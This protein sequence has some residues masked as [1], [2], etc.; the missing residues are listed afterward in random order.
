MLASP[1]ST[2]ACSVEQLVSLALDDAGLPQLQEVRALAGGANHRALA[3][4]LVDGQRLFAK[5]CLPSDVDQRQRL[6]V[7]HLALRLMWQ[8][9]ERAIPEPLGYLDE[10]CLLCRFVEGRP[11]L[12]RRATAD[13]VAQLVAFIDRLHRLGLETARAAAPLASDA[14]LSLRQART[15][16]ERRLARLAAVESTALG[17]FLEQRFRPAL[18][19]FAEALSADVLD[20]AGLVVLSPSDFGFHNALVGADG[21]R[22]IF[23]DFEY[24]GWDDAGKLI[25]DTLLHPQHRELSLPL[26][27]QL[28]DGMLAVYRERD[29]AL[30]QRVR[31]GYALHALKWCLIVLKIYL[32]EHQQRMCNA[33]ALDGDLAERCAERL[34]AAEQIVEQLL[35]RGSLL[36][37][38]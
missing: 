36:D 25:A 33:S 18:A 12:A 10:R 6:A 21:A 7:E 28:R 32:P 37:D 38:C 30:W 11:A 34:S 15:A 35:D 9:G 2:A 17:R 16:I 19:Q 23:V 29:P 31:C 13:Q 5:V 26:R 22:L 8:A 27:R 24:F 4:T 20:R 14:A 3:L 1:R